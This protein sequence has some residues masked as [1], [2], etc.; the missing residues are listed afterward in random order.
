MKKVSSCENAKVRKKNRKKCILYSIQ[1]EKK[2]K[3]TKLMVLYY[4]NL[5][6][7]KNMIIVKSQ[8]QMTQQTHT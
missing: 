1:Q 2:W 3:T 4:V 8:T 6:M 7:K 5:I